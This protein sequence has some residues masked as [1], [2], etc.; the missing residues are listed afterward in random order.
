MG[1]LKP[2]ITKM[3]KISRQVGPLGKSW[4]S[5]FLLVTKSDWEEKRAMRSHRRLAQVPALISLLKAELIL[6]GH[7][8]YPSALFYILRT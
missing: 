3:S 2:K 1:K 4:M 6:L 5:K 7:P 8:I